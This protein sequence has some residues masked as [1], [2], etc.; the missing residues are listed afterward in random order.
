MDKLDFAIEVL[1]VGFFVV[2]F[3]L[4]VLY[5]IL[6][7]F[8]HLFHRKSSKAASGGL[9]GGKLASGTINKDVE[10]RTTAAI[11]AAV[12]QYMQEYSTFSTTGSIS[13]AIQPSVNYRGNNWQMV[14]R[15]NTLESRSDLETIRRK[16]QRENI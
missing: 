9:T 6:I 7:L 1:L 14:G 10:G 15:K 13:I 11:V 8:N 2:M 16:K 12:S 5:G 3:T 4:F